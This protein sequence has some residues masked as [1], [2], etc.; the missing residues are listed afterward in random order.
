MTMEGWVPEQSRP[1]SC[2]FYYYNSTMYLVPCELK[3]GLVP[4]LGTI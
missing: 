2:F 1:A 4:S 3:E